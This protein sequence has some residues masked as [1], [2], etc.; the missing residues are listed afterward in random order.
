M[1]YIF[2]EQFEYPKLI[3]QLLFWSNMFSTETEKT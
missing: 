1:L 2:V 3:L